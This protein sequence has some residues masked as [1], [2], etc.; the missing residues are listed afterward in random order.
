MNNVSVQAHLKS[1]AVSV[2]SL[3]RSPE[4]FPGL[5]LESFTDWSRNRKWILIWSTMPALIAILGF[6]LAGLFLSFRSSSSIVQSA[7]SVVDKKIPRDD[8]ESLAFD[9]HYIRNRIKVRPDPT[10]YIESSSSEE[11]A[12]KKTELVAN[13][14]F[15]NSA[16]FR[17]SEVLLHRATNTSSD[18]IQAK[19][20]LALLTSL[21]S[22]RPDR[23]KEA[24]ALMESLAENAME[25]FPPAHAWLAV[26][27]YGLPKQ[28]DPVEIIQLDNY[29][30]I[31]SKWKLIEP[32][33][34]SLYSSIC[35]QSGQ[36]KKALSMAKLAAEF[37]PELN[38]AYAQICKMLGPEHDREL[39]KAAKAAEVAFNSKLG[40][41]LE[42][43]NDRIGLA[44]ALLLQDNNEQAIEI[45]AS[46]LS[47]DVSE[48]KPLR[49]GLADMYIDKFRS[50]NSEQL[51][52]ADPK[53]DDTAAVEPGESADVALPVVI[54]W[55][56][57]LEAAKFD[58]DNPVVGQEIAMQWRKLERPPRE[59]LK[60]LS[61]QL[62]N[63]I[64]SNGARVMVAE[65]YLIAGRVKEARAQWEH[66]LQ[67]DPYVIPA[68][69]NLAVLLSRETPPNLS[70]AIELIDRAYRIQ[71][72]SAE[73]CDTYG[74]VYM[75]AGRPMDAIAK[76][77]ESIRLDPTRK[78]TRKRLSDCYRQLGMNEM[79]EEQ[80]LQIRKLTDAQR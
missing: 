21:D 64:A 70:R 2:F 33:L 9:E 24:D 16:K 10:I 67:K 5:L 20:R 50:D 62:Q 38:L 73:M 13:D 78:T 60:V 79:A 52:K 17:E 36:P 6:M 63:D 74:E 44:Q 15:V 43:D 76:L 23:Q 71:P 29:L 25:E 68:L 56:N 41:P 59:L 61:Y 14:E 28:L 42:T 18:S 45:L 3:I 7:L 30:R 47:E 48:H 72:M 69:N 77:E 53:R 1:L 26:S 8:L 4:T 37:R 65:L 55:T 31:A 51:A 22:K 12:F 34:L 40:T 49:R 66:I 58:R 54:D 75:N 39:Q 46:G 80:D 27:L 19:Y 32:S 35:L 11:P 57:L